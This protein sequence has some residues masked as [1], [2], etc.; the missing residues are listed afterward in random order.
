M[1]LF[2]SAVDLALK[3]HSN[4][5]VSKYTCNFPGRNKNSLKLMN[6]KHFIHL[7]HDNTISYI[8]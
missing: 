2:K 4:M 3:L 6:D 1:C 7:K 8:S 5:L